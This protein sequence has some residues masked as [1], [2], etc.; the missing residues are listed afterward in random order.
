MS[1]LHAQVNRERDHHKVVLILPE[2]AAHFFHDADNCEFFIANAK[3]F[4]EW[5]DSEKELLQERVADQADV[6]AVIRFRFSEIA[7]SLHGAGVDVR[8]AWRVTGKVNVGEFLVTVARAD[9][10]A[11]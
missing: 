1:A 5:I 8:H 9:G 4:A 3:G 2:N 7:A 10:G 6:G 11:G